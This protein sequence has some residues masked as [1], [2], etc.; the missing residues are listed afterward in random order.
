MKRYTLPLLL[1]VAFALVMPGCSEEPQ[2]AE[3]QMLER[4]EQK[5]KEGKPLTEQEQAEEWQTEKQMLKRLEQK[6]KE[7]KALTEQEQ[8][9]LGRLTNK[10]F[11]K[12][13][14]PR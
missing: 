2:T 12:T 5:R 10:V 13:G 9:D 14:K 1:L 7:G 6:M 4:F 11:N 3:K 8:R